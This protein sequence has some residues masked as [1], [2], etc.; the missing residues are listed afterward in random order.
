MCASMLAVMLLSM[1]GCAS[2]GDSH[3]TQPIEIK[4]VHELTPFRGP[5]SLG[6]TITWREGTVDRGWADLTGADQLVRAAI[7]SASSRLAAI[8]YPS[9]S[10]PDFL[11]QTR[12]LKLAST[13]F[14]GQNAH[15]DA[16]GEGSSDHK[17]WVLYAWQGP[18]FPPHPNRPQVHR[19]LYVY[20]LYDVEAKQ[21]TRLLATIHGEAQE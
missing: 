1:S 2:N 15:M 17:K 21:V 12:S 8:D 6:Q 10:L 4:T 18:E 16:H 19:W 20:A 3:P 9:L 7:S 13:D 14:T 5:D 11:T